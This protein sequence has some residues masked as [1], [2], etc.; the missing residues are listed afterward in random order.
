MGS[1]AWTDAQ[2]SRYQTALDAAWDD[3]DEAYYAC[4]KRVGIQSMAATHASNYMLRARN[5]K[6]M[7]EALLAKP[8]YT[9]TTPQA[10]RNAVAD[11]VEFKHAVNRL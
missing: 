7:V 10:I 2:R 9:A 1:E 3:F 8:T 6:Q 11:L 4:V 5:I